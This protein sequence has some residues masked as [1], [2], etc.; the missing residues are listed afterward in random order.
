MKK[1]ILIV[2]DEGPVRSLVSYILGNAGYKVIEAVSAMEALDK[3]DDNAPEMVIADLRLPNMNG[4][5]FAMELRKKKQ[6]QH[7]PLVMLTSEFQ[8][9]RNSEGEKAGVNEWIAKPFIARQ[10]LKTVKK[11]F[12]GNFSSKNTEMYRT[13]TNHEFYVDCN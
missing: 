4:I 7:L 12:A 10:L 1:R 9:Y 2:D 8:G 13:G 5:E 11:L 6:Y 3:L